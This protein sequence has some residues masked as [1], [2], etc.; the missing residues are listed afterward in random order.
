MKILTVFVV[1]LAALAFWSFRPEPP[2]REAAKND[3]VAMNYAL[4]RTAVFDYALRTKT[5]GSVLPGDPGL[6]L[7]PSGWR[8]IRPWQGL[9]QEEADE[10]LYC[11][12]FGPAQ[13][14]EVLAVQKL[15]NNS[16]AVGWNNAGDLVRNGNPLSLPSDIPHGAIV[17]I[18]RLD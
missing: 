9:I 12:V 11:Y 16:K 10:Q 2:D 13:P 3:S 7:L 4:F 15:F 8:N 17:S 5:S 6:T 18:M 1:L 14:D